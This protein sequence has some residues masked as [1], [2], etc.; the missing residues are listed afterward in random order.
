MSVGCKQVVIKSVLVVQNKIEERIEHLLSVLLMLKVNPTKTAKM[1]A[2]IRDVQMT[3][4]Q[5][6]YDDSIVDSLLDSNRNSFNERKG[7]GRCEH[8]VPIYRFY[9]IDRSFCLFYLNIV[10]KKRIF[11]CMVI[12]DPTIIVFLSFLAC[13]FQN[14]F[15]H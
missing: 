4:S 11:N 9:Q 15:D 1:R 14:G 7:R 6:K 13:S 5:L 8:L 3:D 2:N 10:K 12:N